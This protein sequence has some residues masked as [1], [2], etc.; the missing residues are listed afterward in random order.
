MRT[1]TWLSL[2]DQILEGD[3]LWYTTLQTLNQTGYKNWN[4]GEPNQSFKDE[5][6]VEYS[7]GRGF[8]W[9]DDYCNLLRNLICENQP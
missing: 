5:N 2:T 4:S 6:C 9:N 7:F 1:G 3:W 8:G